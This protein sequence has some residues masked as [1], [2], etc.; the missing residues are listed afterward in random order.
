MLAVLISVTEWDDLVR[1]GGISGRSGEISLD[2]F[3]ILWAD[4]QAWFEDPRTGGGDGA[5]PLYFVHFDNYDFQAERDRG[6]LLAPS[7]STCPWP[8]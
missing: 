8:R 4:A 6:T 3:T 7:R 1:A 5:Q 2:Q